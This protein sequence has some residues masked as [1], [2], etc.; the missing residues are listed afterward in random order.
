[1]AMQ[2]GTN[3]SVSACFRRFENREVSMKLAKWILAGAMLMAVPSVTLAQQT[4]T[5]TVVAIDR[6]NG[7]IGIQQAQSGTVGA[8]SGGAI[9]QEYKAPEGSL[10]NVHAGDRVA[11]S[12]SEIGG[13][14]TIT[15]FES[16]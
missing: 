6:I 11:F 15:K 10:D 5:G 13:K 3:P 16:K 7:T 14:K 2:Q 4:L 8:D 12:A 9:E 1:M